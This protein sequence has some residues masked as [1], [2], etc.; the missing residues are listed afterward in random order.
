VLDFYCP[1]HKLAVEADGA[2]HD[3]AD[4]AEYDAVRTEALEQLGIRVVRVRNE[5][6][7]HDIMG[8][9]GRVASA[10]AGLRRPA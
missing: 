2:V 5:D 10:A 4:Q 6:V 7:L 1:A 9:M 8:V 3:D